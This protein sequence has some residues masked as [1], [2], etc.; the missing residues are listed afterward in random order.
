MLHVK[1]SG[2]FGTQKA[3]HLLEHPTQP[4]CILLTKVKSITN[5][6]MIEKQRNKGF[7]ISNWYAVT[8]PFKQLF[9]EYVAAIPN[10]LVSWGIFSL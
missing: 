9:Q 2:T 7:Y 3:Q 5:T 8:K 10:H 1:Q 6:V 4:S